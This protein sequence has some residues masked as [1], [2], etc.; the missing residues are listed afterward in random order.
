M[1]DTNV[2]MIAA[3][4]N[5]GALVLFDKETQQVMHE[6][7]DLHL[8]ECWYVLFSAVDENVVYTCADD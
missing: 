6:M 5:T 1:H 2:K 8:F 4:M 3:V 7:Q